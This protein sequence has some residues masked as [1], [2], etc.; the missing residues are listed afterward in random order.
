MLIAASMMPPVLVPSGWPHAA[1]RSVRP[2]APR[3][4]GRAEY[5]LRQPHVGRAGMVTF[6]HAI[7][8]DAPANLAM[9]LGHTV[10]M[11][12]WMRRTEQAQARLSRRDLRSP[13]SMRPA[14]IFMS[15]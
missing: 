1:T 3:Q 4:W 10:A 9:S 12:D 2:I 6:L 13:I 14:L 8:I 7:L 5:Y 11:T 15:K